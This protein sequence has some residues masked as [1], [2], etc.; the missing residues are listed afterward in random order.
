M[1]GHTK[2]P[3]SF[4]QTKLPWIIFAAALALYWATLN[5]WVTLGSLVVVSKLSG[6]DWWT[7]TLYNPLLYLAGYPFQ[8]FP[9]NLRPYLLNLASAVM[10]ALT[11]MLLARSVALLPHD[12]TREQRRAETS[13]LSL[14]SVRLAWLPPLLAVVVCGLQLSFWEHATSATGE[15][16]DLLLFA[17]CIRCLLEYRID[18]RQSWLDKMAFVYGVAATNNWAMIGFFPAF[19]AALIWIKGRSFFNLAF[20]GR[21]LLWGF[22]GLSLY[23]FLPLRQLGSD[24]SISVLEAL[25]A[26][27]GNQKFFLVDIPPLR[28]RVLLLSLTS[29]LPVLIMGIR[30]PSTFGET[31]FVGALLTSVMFRFVHALFLLG[32]IWVAFDPKFSPRVLGEAASEGTVRYLTFYYLGAL[33]VGYYSGYFLLLYGLE[34]KHSR[35]RNEGSWLSRRLITLILLI[36]PGLV[37]LG[38]LFKNQ[39]YIRGNNGQSLKEF[40]AEQAQGLPASGAVVL[41]DNPYHLYLLQAMLDTARQSSNHVLLDTRLLPYDLYRQRIMKRWPGLFPPSLQT[42][43]DSG[44]LAL[45]MVN[46]ARQKPLYYL[47]PSF[48]YYFERFYLRPRGPLY[49]LLAYPTNVVVPPAVTPQEIQ[50]NERFW[51]KTV[52]ALVPLVALSEEK[53]PTAQFL[54]RHYALALNFWGTEMQKNNRLEEAG[55]SFAAALKLNPDN[56]SAKVNSQFNERLRKGSPARMEPPTSVT[57]RFGKHLGWLAVLNADGPFD[58]PRFCFE[59]GQY[60]ARNEVGLYRQAAIQ[61]ARVQQLDPEHLTARY[62][63]ANMCLIIELPE[64]TLELI[65]E[66]RRDQ[67]TPTPSVEAELVRLEALAE[68]AQGNREKAES[69]LLSASAKL[70]QEPTILE[71]LSKIY[72]FTGRLTNAMEALVAELRIAPD[73]VVALR[74]LGAT[75]IQLA[76]TETNAEQKTVLYEKAL[77]P[78]T[79]ALELNPSDSA[80]LMNRAIAELQSGRL[81]EAQR[82]YQALRKILP[83]YFPIYYGLAEVAF[84]QKD[85]R[86]AVANYQLYLKHAPRDTPETDYV[87]TRL[88]QARAGTFSP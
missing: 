5:H 51:T 68:N 87:L 45:G 70:P 66:V 48:G 42:N 12:R 64:K 22:I 80:A 76:N 81:T 54:S 3:S 34:T 9:P 46:A 62:W 74:N 84:R 26:N 25:R 31:S 41:S 29:L 40:A 24:Q 16:L 59:L 47:H 2:S 27:L 55:K 33:C 10:A 7:T 82:D 56:V 37:A 14:L 32:C 58:E 52:P 15:M 85:S 83:T 43:A 35:T 21:L 72:L 28:Y 88:K 30:W 50:D 73:N 38:L 86:N 61:F 69:I 6:W 67:P 20:M 78:L 49:E 65:R 75:Y 13:D 4:A 23:L 17:Y 63:L 8:L 79:R 71:T 11:L 60:M 44:A 19:L 39:A 1:Q 18:E 57:D 36:A 53:N 77:V